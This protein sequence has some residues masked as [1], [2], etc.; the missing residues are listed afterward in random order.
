MFDGNY[1]GLEEETM[2]F[3]SDFVSSN[4]YLLEI[5]LVVFLL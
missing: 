3:P 5:E 4:K 2:V 1:R